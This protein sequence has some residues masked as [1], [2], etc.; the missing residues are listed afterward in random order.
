MCYSI[1]LTG[2]SFFVGTAAWALGIW[3]AVVSDSWRFAVAVTAVWYGLWMQIPDFIA[4]AVYMRRGVE[5]TEDQDVL[6][7]GK[8]GYVAAFIGFWLTSLQPTV[9][10]VLA[11]CFNTKMP[12]MQGI[13]GAVIVLL[14][15]PQIVWWWLHRA[16][17]DKWLL[18][19]VKHNPGGYFAVNCEL[20]HAWWQEED[21]ELDEKRHWFVKWYETASSKSAF[22]QGRAF[23]YLLNMLIGTV[24][25]IVGASQEEPVARL[26]IGIYVGMSMVWVTAA[27]SLLLTH[28]RLE[29]RYASV[30]CWTT[31]LALLAMVMSAMME[32]WSRGSEGAQPRLQW[33]ALTE[34]LSLTTGM[35]VGYVVRYL[36]VESEGSEGSERRSERRS[37]RSEEKESLNGRSSTRRPRRGRMPPLLMRTTS[38]KLV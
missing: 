4:W 21:A 2:G 14:E 8:W 33:F 20:N 35:F 10:N 27:L 3:A 24:F 32:E 31:W 11:I 9:V 29:G 22:P 26:R 15:A 1:E 17:R 5:A 36:A 23:L 25:V 12:W 18:Y 37:E 13:S 6:L 28:R 16:N 19:R 7:K 30:W 34:G 38:P